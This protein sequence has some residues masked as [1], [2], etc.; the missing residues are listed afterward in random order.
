MIRALL[1]DCF[2]VFYVDPVFAYTSS[3]NTSPQQAASMNF[4]KE[5]SAQGALSK[6][7]FIT[8]ASKLLNETPDQAKK[9]FF[10]GLHRNNELITFVQKAHKHYKT[11]L[12]SNIGKDMIDGFFTTQELEALFDVV[13]LSGELG[14]AKPDPRIYALTLQKLGVA[15]S[16]ALFIDDS[17]KHVTGAEAVGIKSILYESNQQLLKELMPLLQID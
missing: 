7:A 5:Q 12:V 3:P 15:P 6:A 13:A 8:E 4:L 9:Q 11:A 10:Q 17:I 14:V 2:G 1:F 16:D